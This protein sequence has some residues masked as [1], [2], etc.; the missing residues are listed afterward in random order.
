MTALQRRYQSRKPGSVRTRGRGKAT[1][2]IPEPG[3]RPGL[4]DAD[5]IGEN[6]RLVEV[7]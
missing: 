4:H 2:M 3:T 5:A 6:D 1:S 7:V